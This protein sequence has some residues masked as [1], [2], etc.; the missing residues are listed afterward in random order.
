MNV[1]AVVQQIGVKAR[2]VG[3]LPLKERAQLRL[4]RAQSEAARRVV[5]AE[6]IDEVMR[7]ECLDR[8]EDARR[9]VAELLHCTR[10]KDGDGI[11]RSTRYMYVG[12]H[13][14]AQ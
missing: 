7:E 4:D 12:H 8:V 11:A 1:A 10:R 2:P 9:S 3:R 6:V 14:E 13:Q 5:A